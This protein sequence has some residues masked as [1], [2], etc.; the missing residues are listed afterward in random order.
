[1]SNT[2]SIHQPDYLPWAGFFDKI[3]KSDIFI[4]FDTAQFN[5]RVYQ[6]RNR[7]KTDSNNSWTYLTIPVEKMQKPI[8]ELLI[9]K[10][11]WKKKHINYIIQYYSKS[12][13]FSNYIGFFKEYYEKENEFLSDFNLGLINYICKCLNI[14]TKIILASELDIDYVNLKATDVNIAMLK[15]V[16]AQSYISGSFGKKYLDSKKFRDANISLSFQDFQQKEYHQL[17]GGFVPNLSIIDMLFNLGPETINY[18]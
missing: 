16:G 9:Q 7:I 13:Y 17:Y 4:I 6:H 11:N 10:N 2:V 5:R 15:A 14:K 8:N 3:H 18:I 12:K 1:M